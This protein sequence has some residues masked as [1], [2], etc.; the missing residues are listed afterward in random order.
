LKF[1]WSLDKQTMIDDLLC[2]WL[3]IYDLIIRYFKYLS[4]YTL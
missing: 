3:F 2:Y 4:V 1:K